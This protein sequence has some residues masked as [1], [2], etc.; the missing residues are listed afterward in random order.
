MTGRNSQR[1][2]VERSAELTSELTSSIRLWSVK[3]RG[4]VQTLR[5]LADELMEH[6][7]NVH[8]AKLS[9][10]SISIGG[11]ILVAT[12]FGLAAVTVGTSLILSAV[13]GA[14]SAGGGAT[15]AGSGIAEWKIFKTKL[16]TAQKAIDA[17]R[18][19]QEPVLELLNEV[20]KLSCGYMK[21]HVAYNLSVASL[22]KNLVDLVRGV[23][24][25]ARVATTA[26]SEGAEVVVR[27]IG[28]G[29]N[30]VRIGMFAFSAVLLP[31]D[32]YTLVKS[33]MEIDSARKGKKDKEPEAV[34]KLREV[35]NGLE[36]EMNEML[37][38]V[39]EFQQQIH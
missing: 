34:K 12:G 35:A 21:D 1:D 26:A 14:I 25:G 19:A 38:A 15:V 6:H 30:A 31:L 33:S 7:K 8:I 29:A 16:T 27:S 23:K 39:D 5:S 18:E 13:G 4:T 10:S 9:G 3:R 11:F 22:V 37:Q 36:T 17:D 24:A 32:L 2:L 20:S 28:I